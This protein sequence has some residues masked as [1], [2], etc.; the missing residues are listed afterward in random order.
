MRL[1]PPQPRRRR[2]ADKFVRV[3]NA[4]IA[5]VI[6]GTTTRQPVRF[7]PSVRV[8]P[9]RAT[10]AAGA[11]TAERCLACAPARRLAGADHSRPRQQLVEI[12]ALAR[13][14]R[15]LAVGGDE[16]LELAAAVLALIFEDWHEL[17]LTRGSLLAV[18]G[19]RL[20]CRLEILLP[21]LQQP[22]ASRQPPCAVTLHSVQHS[23]LDIQQCICM[24]TIY[25]N[26]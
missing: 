24:I 10:R 3:F 21:N 14:A 4:V 5:A 8:R 18:G 7:T 12:A 11:T 15:R 6:A 9:A 25:G 26:Q 17:I 16:G 1:D 19:S 22:A 23:A 2:A 13:R 20:Q